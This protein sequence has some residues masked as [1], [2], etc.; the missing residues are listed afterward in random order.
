MGPP[1][2]DSA[3]FLVDKFGAGNFLVWNLSDEPTHKLAR[4]LRVQVC[5]FHWSAPGKSQTPCLDALFR[6]CYSI[7]VCGVGRWLCLYGGTVGVW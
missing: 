1:S 5:D 6:I 4:P 3:A 2:V 7:N